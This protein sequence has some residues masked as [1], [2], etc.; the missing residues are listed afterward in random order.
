M[1]KIITAREAACLVQDNDTIGISA[2]AAGAGFAEHVCCALEERFLESGNPQNLTLVIAS[3][4]GDNTER[5]FALN[6]FAYEKMLGR[7]VSGHVGLSKKFSALIAADKVP[8]WNFPQGV[9]THL[10][11][12]VAGGKPGVLTHVGLETF[13]DPR[14][15]GGKMNPSA[16]EDLVDVVTINGEEK[17][18]YRAFPINVALI[19]GT[20]ADEFGN[21]TMEHEAL[22][23]EALPVAQAAKNSG[24]IVIAQVERVARRGSLNPMEV[25][26]PGI[27]VDYV[28]LSPPEHHRMNVLVDYNPSYSGE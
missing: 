18:L 17:L 6:H 7:V 16:R 14:V 10:F 12:A 11:R 25:Q 28:V 2:F 5:P 24:G 19:R 8:A 13:A 15:E 1:Q 3:G 9:V 21:L 23:T 22:L 20:T 4:N 27:L 26:V